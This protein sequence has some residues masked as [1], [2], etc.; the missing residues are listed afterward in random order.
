MVVGGRRY[1]TAAP[2]LVAIGAADIVFAIDSIP[3]IFVDRSLHRL[4]RNI[5]LSSVCGRSTSR[6]L[7]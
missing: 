4:R 6:L 1:A 3:A 5:L 7:A 2:V